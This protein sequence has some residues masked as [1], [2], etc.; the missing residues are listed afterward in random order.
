MDLTLSSAHIHAQATRAAHSC[1]HHL[2]PRA[3]ARHQAW[4]LADPGHDPESQSA[5]PLSHGRIRPQRH[6]I[7]WPPLVDIN[8]HAGLTSKPPHHHGLST[9]WIHTVPRNQVGVV[10]GVR[11]HVVVIVRIHVS[12]DQQRSSPAAPA[13]LFYRPASA[14]HFAP[15][16][17]LHSAS[18]ALCTSSVHHH[19]HTCSL[20]SALVHHRAPTLSDTHSKPRLQTSICSCI[21]AV[22]RNPSQHLDASVTVQP[23]HHHD[24]LTLAVTPYWTPSHKA[25]ATPRAQPSHTDSARHVSLRDTLTRNP[26]CRRKAPSEPSSTPQADAPATPSKMHHLP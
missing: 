1:R 3:I 7:C 15:H 14:R 13:L 18:H 19:E 11:L 2:R 10:M 6:F 8:Q 16:A 25:F 26:A 17:E 9:T 22:T 24:I 21:S 4:L 12:K 5:S 20:Q 23:L